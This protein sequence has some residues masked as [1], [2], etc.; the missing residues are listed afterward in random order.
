MTLREVRK[1][2]LE[3]FKNRRHKVIVSASLVPE[4]DI[5]TLFTGSGMQPL[6]PYLL[7]KEHPLGKR[8][9]D[10][11]KSFRAEDID[12]VGDNRHT[13]FFEMLGNWSFGDY[14]KEEQ[15]PWFFEFLTAPESKGGVGLDP[16][17]LY[18]SVFSGDEENNIPRDNESVKIWQRLFKE[19]G[20][21]AKDIELVTIEEGGRKGMQGGRIF[22]Y[23]AK[24][25][26]WSRS[27][28][29][30]N[31]PAGEPG[32]PDS[33]V[34]YEFTGITH[35]PKFGE[36][37]HPNCDCGRFVEIGNSV[38]M[39]YKKKE[40]GSFG[41]L[42]QRNVDFGGGLE[43][44]AAASQG[45]ANVF[46]IDVFANMHAALE[47][48]GGKISVKNEAKLRVILDHIRASV[49]L[50]SDGVRPSNK[51]QGYVLR[52]LLRRSMAHAKL[53]SFPDE[54]MTALRD[55]VAEYYC[56]TYANLENEKESINAVMYEEFEKFKKILDSGLK[57]IEK[58]ESISVD[59][60]FMLHQSCGFP[61]ELTRELAREKG[62]ELSRKEFD[63]VFIKHQEVSRAGQEKKFGGHGLMFDT[64]E[65]RAAS[66]EDYEKV[67]RLH[68]A[69]HMLQQALRT[70]LGEEV[71]Q[72][73]SDITAERTR[74][75]FTFPRKLTPEEIARVEML[76]N[77]KI[78]EDLPMNKVVL[79]KAEA[80]KTGALYFFKGKYPD[81]VNVY[82]LG[83]DIKTAWSKEFC[84]GPHISHTGEI[85]NFKI[86][87]EEA[88]GGGVRRI[89][90]TVTP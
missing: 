35:N 63:K 64:G 16:E 53:L 67:V 39:E 25:N 70:V 83:D 43:R 75:D 47:T 65:L 73:G 22:Y 50:I 20:I 7:G 82:Y 24:K 29:P 52:R 17:R 45:N 76:V 4:G 81:Q 51:G 68:T 11:Q 32:G 42:A 6:L 79:S 87:K 28:V 12:E 71:H 59:D 78:K 44:I 60:A 26:W 21:E 14:F 41:K 40:D 33:E 61:F 3:F 2:Y 62:I 69:T 8:V 10:S 58:M 34:F 84:G 23:G 37:C 30:N 36:H 54:W 27:G 74:F 13:T 85:G 46:N 5:T 38:F 49:F 56:D 80:E 89:R 15:L 90:A 86:I 1:K 88:V 72:A 57:Q 9:T 55:T 18:V 31:M 19:K 77:E 66:K 48:L